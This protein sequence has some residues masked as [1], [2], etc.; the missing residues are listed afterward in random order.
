MIKGFLSLFLGSVLFLI[1]CA[2]Q[3][4]PAPAPKEKVKTEFLLLGHRSPSGQAGNLPDSLEST[5][6]SEKSN[7][8]IAPFWILGSL[9]VKEEEIDV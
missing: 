6:N 2:H 4:P 9:K 5:E 8:F 7:D 1:H 3:P